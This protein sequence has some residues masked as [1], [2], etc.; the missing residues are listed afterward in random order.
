MRFDPLKC[1]ECGENATG[2]LE[3][4]PNCVANL[5]A[6]DEKGEVAYDG[7]TDV[8]WDG[9]APMRDLNGQVQLQCDNDHEWWAKASGDVSY[10]TTEDYR[11]G[12]DATVENLRQC[13]EDRDK[14][15][16]ELTAELH[17]VRALA[18]DPGA[19]AP[20]EPAMEGSA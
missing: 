10:G 9:Q 19:G 12:R 20:L 16:R 2:I 15:I 7:N 5:A 6:P 14:K 1:P 13:V 8:N 18:E 17:R 4:I 11:R 3:E